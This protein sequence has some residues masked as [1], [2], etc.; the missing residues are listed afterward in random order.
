MLQRE[1][2]DDGAHRSARL[3]QSEPQPGQFERLQTQRQQHRQCREQEQPRDEV[4][5]VPVPLERHVPDRAQPH[6]QVGPPS[7]LRGLRVWRGGVGRQA[8][9]QHGG[10]HQQ[11]R[12]QPQRG[13]DA[14]QQQRA[15]ERGADQA[16][17]RL[18][19]LLR[20]QQIGQAAR[21]RRIDQQP[22]HR[23][24]HHRQRRHR[25]RAQRDQRPEVIAIGAG[26]ARHRDRGHRVDRKRCDDQAA[27]VLAIGQW[28]QQ[29]HRDQPDR[30]A[31]DRPQG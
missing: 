9:R 18:H 10:Q 15:A 1:R 13:G 6:H 25:D 4:D 29:R 7:R 26:Q 20:R 31:H 5:E 8:H 22:V 11:Q 28:R 23:G 12:M 21:R 30:G 27:A 14:H 2:A 24:V 17:D 16:T 19:A 3:A